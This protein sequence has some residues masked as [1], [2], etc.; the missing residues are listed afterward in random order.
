MSFFRHRKIKFA[1]R[2]TAPP[3]IRCGSKRTRKGG[4]RD[5]KQKYRCMD[6]TRVY[7]DLQRFKA[8]PCVCYR[9]GWKGECV[10]RRRKLKYKF[11]CPVCRKYFTQG[12][13]ADLLKYRAHLDR[14]I[15]DLR[16]PKEV[17]LE[18]SSLA[19]LAVMQGEGYCWNLDLKPL[20]TAA[21][22]N[23]TGEYRQ[24]GSEHPIFARDALG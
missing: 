20:V 5:G 8:R 15:E 1:R 17:A 9:C 21:W 22:R 18:L 23:E 12:G 6:C 16:L 4:V 24:L 11:H 14:R 13:P 3:C 7:Y 2:S 10:P 19:A